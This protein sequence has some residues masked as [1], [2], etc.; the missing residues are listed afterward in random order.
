[1]RLIAR[2]NGLAYKEG[3]SV[4]VGSKSL[5]FGVHHLLWHPLTVTLAW[6][7]L[8]GLPNYKEFICI[9]VHDWGYFNANDMNDVEGQK[10]P[11]LGSRI[12]RYLFGVEYETLCLCH[13]RDYSRAH[14]MAPSKLCY[15]DKLSIAFDP[16]FFYLLRARLTGELQLYRELSE[17]SGVVLKDC[18]DNEWFKWLREHLVAAGTRSLGSV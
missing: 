12:A 7:K 14:G 4:R 16:M 15:A 5:L 9:I 3:T 1:M 17:K 10:H 6:I 8:F 18:P 11:I 2:P 13:S